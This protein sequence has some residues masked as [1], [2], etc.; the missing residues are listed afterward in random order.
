M[1]N[2]LYILT[3]LTV[4]AHTT[5]HR[6]GEGGPRIPQRWKIITPEDNIGSDSGSKAIEIYR[7]DGYRNVYKYVDLKTMEI[8]RFEAIKIY[9]FEAIEMS[10]FQTV[11]RYSISMAPRMMMH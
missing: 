8:L 2:A 7:F 4:S 3:P 9:R 5:P 6:R 10:S 1:S 11:L